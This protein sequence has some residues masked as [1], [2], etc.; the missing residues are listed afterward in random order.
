VEPGYIEATDGAE[1]P[2]RS[3]S[4]GARRVWREEAAGQV[5]TALCSAVLAGRPSGCVQ[6]PRLG[7]AGAPGTLTVYAPLESEFNRVQNSAY[8]EPT[9]REGRLLILAMVWARMN[10]LCSS[11]SFSLNHSNYNYSIKDP[12]CI[13][14]YTCKNIEHV[15]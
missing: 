6:K 1:P 12:Y 7:T 11:T 4:R 9:R 10:C 5:G 3:P 2:K 8:Q 15:Q 14:D 13:Q